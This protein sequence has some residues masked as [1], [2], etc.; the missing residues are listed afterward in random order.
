MPR[1]ISAFVSRFRQLAP[2]SHGLRT[3]KLRPFSWSANKPLSA[4]MG[5][6]HD[7]G[8]SGSQ[9]VC[10]NCMARREVT[11]QVLRRFTDRLANARASR[12]HDRLM[13]DGVAAIQLG[14]RRDQYP[15]LTSNL[16]QFLHGEPEKDGIAAP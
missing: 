8:P 1:L 3:A 10:H 14:R 4:G 9:G 12:H 6:R 2:P 16:I 13:S 7:C 15:E 11:N 5:E